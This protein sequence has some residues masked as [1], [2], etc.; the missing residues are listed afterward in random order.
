MLLHLGFG[1]I[2]TATIN[3]VNELSKNHDIE[4]I[5]FYKLEKNQANLLNNKVKVKYL[6]NGGPNKDEFYE[7]IKKKNIFAIIKNGIT[8]IKILLLKKYLIIKEIKETDS[9]YLVSTRNEFSVLLSKYG[10]D[11]TIKIAQEH[12][13]HNNNKKYINN[14]KYNFSNI[15]YLFA[16]TNSLK[17]DYERFLKS[18]KKTKVILVPNMIYL[19]EVRSKLNNKNII[20]V[21]RLHPQKKIDELILI[22]SKLNIDNKLYIIGDGEELNHLKE[23][24]N[25]KN[26]EDKV[27]FTGYLDKEG[28]KKYMLDSSV[29]AMTSVSEGL[30]MVLLEAMSYGIP[31]IAYMTDSGVCDIID[32]EVNGYIIENRNEEKYIDKLRFILENSKCKK[33]FS[34]NALDKANKFTSKNVISIWESVLND[35]K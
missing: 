31:C 34:K 26:I 6:Y 10:N 28:I 15:D 8:A 19:P 30:P 4:I 20:T 13:H 16:L 14:I 22:F 25:S 9:L 32:N 33:E 11:D 29:F 17:A 21:S 3:T 5:S 18:N 1:G 35:E 7:S 23:I 12:Q 2:E 27:I 24:V